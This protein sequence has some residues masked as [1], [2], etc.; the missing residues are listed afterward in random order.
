MNEFDKNKEIACETGAVLTDA[1]DFTEQDS[2]VVLKD[3]TELVEQD[4]K[5]VLID[6]TD[7]AEQDS[8]VV[9]KDAVESEELDPSVALKAAA[10]LA[11][12]NLATALKE[13]AELAELNAATALKEAAE[14]AELNSEFG[15]GRFSENPSSQRE[16]RSLAF[17]LLYIS[18]NYEHKVELKEIA[19]GLRDGFDIY[20]DDSCFA[21]KLAQGAINLREELDDHI[22]PLAKNWM[23]ERIGV[24]TL[25]VLRIALWE[26]LH[27][28]T[29]K[30][31]AINEAIELAK[32]FAEKDSYRFVNG[33]LDEFCQHPGGEDSSKVC[34]AQEL[35]SAP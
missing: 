14:L 34:N 35:V 22:R 24:C 17:H 3:T 11:E 8:N 23:F 7:L 19:A 15:D 29:P 20:F 26:I 1:A 31:V 2:S 32:A 9:L 13:A 30:T 12:L 33:I 18:E 27:S 5:V 4:S 10:E 6:A 21:M 25:L 16:L 28:D